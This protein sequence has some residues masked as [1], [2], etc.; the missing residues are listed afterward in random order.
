MWYFEVVGEKRCPIVDTWWQ[1]ETGAAMISPLPGAWP[2]K[3]GSATLPFFG[4]QVWAIT[5]L[6]WLVPPSIV[7]RDYFLY[8]QKK[9]FIGEDI[10]LIVVECGFPSY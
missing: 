9:V 8:I 1:T 4:V 5:W 3:P 6:R 10:F 2:M 7:Y